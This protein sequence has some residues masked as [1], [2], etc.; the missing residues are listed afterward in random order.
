MP[1]EE[2]PVT[3]QTKEWN[4]CGI[5]KYSNSG[6]VSSFEDVVSTVQSGCSP[7]TKKRRQIQVR[8]VARTLSNLILI[9]CHIHPSSRLPPNLAPPHDA[10]GLQ[11]P[12][13]R[14]TQDW[15]LAP[16]RTKLNSVKPRADLLSTGLPCIYRIRGLA[17]TN[18]CF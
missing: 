3:N 6:N 1:E 9:R 13:P 5:R 11:W 10:Q 12:R 16:V 8:A 7:R 15:P 2:L 18:R 17:G 14:T 4:A